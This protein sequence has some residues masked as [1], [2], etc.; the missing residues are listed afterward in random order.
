MSEM[1]KNGKQIQALG[2]N[3]PEGTILALMKMY[4]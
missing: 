4:N 1:Y 2:L 3:I